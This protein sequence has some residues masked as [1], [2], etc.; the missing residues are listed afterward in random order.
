MRHVAKPGKARRR[1][2]TRVAIQR[3]D[4]NGD[5][6]RNPTRS[7]RVGSGYPFYGSGFFGS[8]ILAEK[9]FGFFSGKPEFFL[10]NPKIL[11]WTKWYLAHLDFQ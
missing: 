11:A 3:L 5:P 9:K 2:V 1:V 6:T 8:S 7:G 10:K 4:P